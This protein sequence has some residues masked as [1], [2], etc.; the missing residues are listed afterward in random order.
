MFYIFVFILGLIFGSFLNVVI[1]RL[2]S[3]DRIVKSRSKCPHCSHRLSARDLW[4]LVSF[5]LSLGRC[6]YC[7]AKISIQYPAVEFI[8]GLLFVLVTYNIIGN[9]GPQYLF[10]N[11]NVLLFWI[12]DLIFICFLVVIFVYDLR[13]YLILDRVTVPAMLVAVVLNLWLGLSL[14][15]L[16]WGL[17]VGLGFFAVQY[18]VSRGKWIGGGDLRMG[19]LMGL[20]LGFPSVITALFLSYIIGAVVSVV[21]LKIKK[22]NLKS[23]VPFGTFLAIGT[24]LTMFWGEEIMRWYFGL[25]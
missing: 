6:R 22:K 21:L 7:K 10:Y 16:L 18:L 25:F 23:Q 17:V 15:S 9:L 14:E 20:M 2:N 13:W 4:P 12:R 8:T 11:T 24:I 5:I 19:A 3:G 1:L